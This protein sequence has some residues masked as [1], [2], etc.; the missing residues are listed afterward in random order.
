MLKLKK[1]AVTGGLAA[2]KTTVCQLFRELGAYIVSADEIVH[3]MLSP[4]T[5]VGQQVVRLLGSDILSGHEINRK[6][7]AAKVFTHPDLLHALEQIIHP[8]VFDE[9]ERRY[10]E[11]LKENRYPLFIAEIPLLYEAGG[12]T[13][14]DAVISVDAAPELCRKRFMEHTRNTSEEFDRRMMRQIHSELKAAKATLTIQNNGSLEELK[15]N[16]KF[17][18][19]QL[20]RGV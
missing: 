7:I 2:G 10:Q 16:V 8:A 3:Q 17:L 9:I 5:V 6:K 14:F 11:I 18:F 4:D 13:G 20:T 15:N 12:E 19:L 1:I